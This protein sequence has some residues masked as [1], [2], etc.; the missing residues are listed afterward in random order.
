MINF[1]I[2][3]IISTFLSIGISIL[4]VEKGNEF[5]IKRF[6]VYLQ[7][8]LRKIHWKMP[9]MLFCSSCTSFWAACISDLIVCC[10]GLLCGVSYFFW[11]FSGIIVAAIMWMII[12]FLNAVDKN[13][14]INVFIDNK[15]LD[16]KE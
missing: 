13:Q 15:E 6:R 8:V 2:C 11:P 4:L 10:I 16:N 5:P 14:D 7:L 1:F 12:E 3:L 9:Q